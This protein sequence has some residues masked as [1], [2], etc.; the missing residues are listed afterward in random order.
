MVTQSSQCWSS[1]W[2]NVFLLTMKIWRSWL[3]SLIT[4]YSLTAIDHGQLIDSLIWVKGLLF[5]KE[6]LGMCLMLIIKSRI[7]FLGGIVTFI[8]NL[9]KHSTHLDL[10][11]NIIT[12]KFKN[13]IGNLTCAKKYYPLLNLSESTWNC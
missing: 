13:I 11:L 4:S 9:W 2:W 12:L 1:I 8:S 3:R 6:T 7:R 5:V 10:V